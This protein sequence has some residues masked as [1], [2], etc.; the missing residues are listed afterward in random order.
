MGM[1][2]R[3]RSEVIRTTPSSFRVTLR[4]TRSSF[5]SALSRID[6]IG[7]LLGRYGLHSR[8]MACDQGA[9]AP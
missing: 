3:V 2:Q 5:A 1:S 6:G 8:S 4:V 7:L 9:A